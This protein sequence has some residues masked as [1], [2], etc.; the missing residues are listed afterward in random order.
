MAKTD[1]ALRIK[2]SGAYGIERAAELARELLDALDEAKG[3]P[4][5]VVELDELADLDL[6]AVQ[7]LYAARHSCQR[8]GLGFGFT[9][10]VS[11]ELS[12]RLLAGGLVGRRVAYG[13]DLAEAFI[14]FSAIG[15]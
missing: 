10:A 3:R 11:P 9:G 5:L 6:P 12:K 7:I 8:R 1:Q 13:E 4:G 2:L 15:A 14:G